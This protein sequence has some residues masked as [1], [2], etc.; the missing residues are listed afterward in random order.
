MKRDYID[1][2]MVKDDHQAIHARLLN[3]ARWVAPRAP[4]WISP[5]FRQYRSHAWQWHTPE[6]REVT[7]TLDAQQIE[8][9]VSKLPDAHREAIRWAYVVCCPPIHAQR[10]LGLT[11]DGLFRHVQDARTML[12]NRLA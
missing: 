10:A 6:V 9:E 4:S 3:W 7:D 12:K 5:M 11:K 2:H 8:K 1:F